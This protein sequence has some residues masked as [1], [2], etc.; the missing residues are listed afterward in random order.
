MRESRAKY[1]G[2][3]G[4]K[5]KQ[6]VRYIA[7][8][9]FCAAL[10]LFLLKLFLLLPSSFKHLLLKKFLF[11]KLKKTPWPGVR[12]DLQSL[13]DVPL[14]WYFRCTS[15]NSRPVEWTCRSLFFFI[16]GDGNIIHIWNYNWIGEREKKNNN[17]KRKLRWKGI[18]NS[19]RHQEFLDDCPSSFGPGGCF[20]LCDR[21][22]ISRPKAQKKKT[23]SC[24]ESRINNNNRKY[25]PTRIAAIA[26]I[27]ST[28]GCVCVF[29]CSCS[30]RA[31]APHSPGHTRTPPHSC[32]S[33]RYTVVH[34]THTHTP[35]WL[36]VSGMCGFTYKHSFFLLFFAFFF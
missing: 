2:I 33:D 32:Y 20:E 34:S 25:S 7:P 19:H 35:S 17:N 16:S 23:K 30:F 5:T 29:T 9:L 31:M 36:C 22:A 6:A 26:G 4:G 13:A 8:L 24:K 21:D 28:V 14:C 15:V 12:N 11:F 10:D 1:G 27:C 3:N 18:A